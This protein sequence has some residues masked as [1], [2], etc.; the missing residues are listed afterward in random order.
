MA[1]D[2]EPQPPS[3]RPSTT[4]VGRAPSEPALAQSLRD[5]EA[6]SDADTQQA[7]EPEPAR[8]SATDLPNLPPTD[9]ELYSVGFEIARGGMGQIFAARDRKLRRDIVVKT[10]SGG[11]GH[12]PRFE[13]EALI[14]ARLQHPSIVRV[15]DAGRLA[16]QPFYAMEHVRGDSLERKVAVCETDNE[17]LALLPHV[18]AIADALAYAHDQGVIHRDLKPA[19]VMIGP[20][21]ETVVIDWGLAKDLH[22]ADWEASDP[23]RGR[24]SMPAFDR[25]GRPSNEHDPVDP[26][27]L[28]VEGAVMG[29]PSYMPPEQARGEPADERSD[30]Y[31]IGGILYFVLSGTPPVSGMRALEDARAGGIT[32]LRDR[33]PDTPPELVSIV[34]HAMAFDPRERYASARELADDLRKFSAG[35]LVGRH[36]YTAKEKVGRWLRRHRTSVAIAAIAIA[37][38]GVLS[39][40]WVRGLAGE[41]DDALAEVTSVRS[42]LEAAQDANDQLALRQA[43][44]TIRRDPTLAIAWLQRLSPRGLDKPEARDLATR[45]ANR[46]IA[47][48]L[49]SP[50]RDIDRIVRAQPIGAVYTTSVDGA[51]YRWQLRAFRGQQLGAHAGPITALA[52]SRDGFWIATG[53][54][55]H[56]V[57][58]WDLE[59]V[60]SRLGAEHGAAVHAVAFSP[61]GNTVASTADD[62]SLWITTVLD[63]KSRALRPNGPELDGVGWL[64]GGKRIAAITGDGRI[65]VVDAATGK[66]ART[67][68]VRTG[69]IRAFVPSPDGRTFAIGSTDGALFAWP[70]DREPHRLADHPGGVHAVTWIDDHRLASAGDDGVRIDD[71]DAGSATWLVDHAPALDLATS[72]TAIAAA[73]RDGKVRVWPLAGGPPRLLAGHRAVVTAVA[74]DGDD[75]LV[76]SAEDRLRL[77]PLPAPPPPPSGA[78]LA[79]WLAERTNVTLAR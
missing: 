38:L 48:E 12:V 74:F 14:T 73:C 30:V 13:R 5:P 32:P 37:L 43:N 57:L 44:R 39:F 76:S 40:V 50:T 64:P 60:Q 20:Y 79:T 71:V 24:P 66:L 34:E 65:L 4:R 28:T 6:I 77:W 25:S 21:G 1:G 35:Q 33:V 67:V 52:T 53:G 45:A 62:G 75:R 54:A 16:S 51:L 17:R 15:Y 23:G 27:N 56:H 29:T 26:A 47:F 63:A 58:I 42:Q 70:T 22:A 19:N 9:P 55:D 11:P 72:H 8:P 2:D 69:A 18:I 68:R 46:G 36:T 7:P 31:A 41:R 3:E 10:L 78:A 49:E 61:D 59:N